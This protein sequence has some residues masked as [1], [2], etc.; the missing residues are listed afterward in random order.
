M[1]KNTLYLFGH[2][3]SIFGLTGITFYAFASPKPEY[4]KFVLI[5][6]GVFALIALVTGFGLL[7]VY[8]ISFSGWIV[9][10][11]LC[12][13]GLTALAAMVFSKAEKAKLFTM[14]AVVLVFLALF[15]VSFKPF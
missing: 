2:L 3:V 7:T 10:K 5:G 14:I 11:L 8:Q 15:M 13:F 4:K 9:V 12:W 6:S 1:D